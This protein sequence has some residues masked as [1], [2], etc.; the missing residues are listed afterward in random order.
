MKIW[1]A[2]ANDHSVDGPWLFDG[3]RSK[4]SLEDE[5]EAEEAEDAT[6]GGGAVPDAFL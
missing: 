6:R 1:D 3:D 5:E 2:A 4:A